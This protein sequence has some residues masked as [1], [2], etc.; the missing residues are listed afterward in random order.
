MTPAIRKV[1]LES[2]SDRIPVIPGEAVGFYKQNCMVC[3][4]LQS[5]KSGVI[6]QAIYKG[7][8]T[9]F[10]V[11]WTGDVTDQILG[12]YRELTRATDFA[13]CALA[14][15]LVRELT[16]FTAIEQSCLG[17]TIDYHLALQREENDLIFNRCARLEVSG[18][19]SENEGNTVDDRI[20][21]KAKRL[22][23]EGNLPDLIA[24]VEFSKPW[25]KMVEV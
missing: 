4:H 15:I 12:A 2:L 19:L 20:R 22:K 10:E 8:A 9:L 24:V 23:P 6:L 3:F 7:K 11:E 14:L 21:Q 25:S 13:A 1:T 5:H 18:I 17:T 16:E